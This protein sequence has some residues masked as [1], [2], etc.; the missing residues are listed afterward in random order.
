M[1]WWD[2]PGLDRVLWRDYAPFWIPRLRPMTDK[3]KKWF[4]FKEGGFP[5]YVKERAVWRVWKKLDKRK[6]KQNH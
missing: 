1:D 3:F 6:S 5:D 2:D 4:P